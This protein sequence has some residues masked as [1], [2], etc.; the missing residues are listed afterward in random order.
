VNGYRFR[1]DRGLFWTVTLVALMLGGVT[2][3][4]LHYATA[5]GR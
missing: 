4:A 2:W 5:L 1:K 3:L